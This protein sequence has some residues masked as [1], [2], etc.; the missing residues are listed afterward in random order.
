MTKH[1]END[2]ADSYG[3]KLYGTLKPEGIFEKLSLPISY[4]DDV[5]LQK[6]GR[7]R[8]FN[9]KGKELYSPEIVALTAFIEE[10][11]SGVWSEGMT[12]EVLVN[13][14][15][16]YFHHHL[17]KYF[18]VTK[19]SE[20]LLQEACNKDLIEHYYEVSSF[21]RLSDIEI[22]GFDSAD[23]RSKLRSLDVVRLDT[24]GNYGEQLSYVNKFFD[25]N[26]LVAL[27][28]KIRAIKEAKNV[29]VSKRR[30]SSDFLQFSVA[31]HIK[32]FNL[33]VLPISYSALLEGDLASIQHK[34]NSTHVIKNIVD[35]SVIV[36]EF[37]MFL[38]SIRLNRS[39]IDRFITQPVSDGDKSNPHNKFCNSYTADFSRVMLN[40]LDFESIK[41]LLR[42]FQ[43]VYPRWDLTI[44]D[45]NT[46]K[47]RFV[48]VKL[49]DNFTS[50]QL[51]RIEEDIKSD[52][53]IELCVVRPTT[54][55]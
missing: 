55:A 53:V 16:R 27:A 31:S 8:K 38:E 7:S 46:K 37:N 28:E 44:L 4:I 40:E 14:F 19:I 52:V 12:I 29:S 18:E 5:S 39:L 30:N 51:L 11:H 54:V 6:S 43:Y 2:M 1:K 3:I 32:E 26:E 42:K 34:I 50:Y 21:Y 9:Y 20:T 24:Y 45:R 23:I 33:G 49:D 17:A 36:Q 13:A 35:V 48:E 47:L 25:S 41:D 15:D 22:E 10:G